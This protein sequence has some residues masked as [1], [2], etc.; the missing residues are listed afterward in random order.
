VGKG[1]IIPEQSIS[2]P[3][4]LYKLRFHSVEILLYD[5]LAVQKFSSKCNMVVFLVR[6]GL[7][8]CLGMKYQEIVMDSD[9]DKDKY[10]NSATEG[11]GATPTFHFTASKF[12]LFRQQLLR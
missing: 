8:C 2:P 10:Y 6:N 4:S 5:V 1:N 11:R 3:S 12:G 9:S 7:V